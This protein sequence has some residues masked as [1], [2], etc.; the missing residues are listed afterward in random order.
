MFDLKNLL[1]NYLKTQDWTLYSNDKLFF[2]I[3]CTTVPGDRDRERERK[4]ERLLG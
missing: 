4:E 3:A 1:Y 2:I